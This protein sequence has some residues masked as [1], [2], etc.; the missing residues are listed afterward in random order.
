MVK[1]KETQKTVE[2]QIPTIRDSKGVLKKLKSKDFPGTKEGR[3]AYCDYRI[4][5]WKV[6]KLVI[7][8]QGDP[9][10]K[11]KARLAKREAEVAKLKAEL[12]EL[13]GSS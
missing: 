12:T 2:Q 13:E 8:K 6:R 10:A 3:L 9:L 4:E 11:K 7:E 5:R 1:Q